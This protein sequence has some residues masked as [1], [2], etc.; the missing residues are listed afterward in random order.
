MIFRQNTTKRKVGLNKT[1]WKS[2]ML[3]PFRIANAHIH[4][5][6]VELKK[7]I[8]ALAKRLCVRRS[9]YYERVSPTKK[10]KWSKMNM[11]QFALKLKKNKNKSFK[12]TTQR[13]GIIA[14]MSIASFVFNIWAFKCA[15]TFQ[16]IWKDFR[17]FLS[18]A[19]FCPLL[20]TLG[21]LIRMTRMK[22]LRQSL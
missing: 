18:I 1:K 19:L 14:D 11:S 20:P 22:I 7:P 4:I 16:L 15:N 13:N 5:L 8:S 9:R 10:E 21:L 17:L 12:Q 2:Q 3:K 6:L